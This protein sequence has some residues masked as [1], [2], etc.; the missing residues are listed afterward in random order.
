MT[1]MALNGVDVGRLEDTIDAISANPELAAFEFRS[2]TY[3]KGGSKNETV[4]ADY[5]GA[6]GELGLDERSFVQAADEPEIL[7]GKDSAPN[8]TEHLLAALAGC[9]TTSLV[10]HAAARGLAVE[11]V[12]AELRGALDLRGF[13]GLSTAVRKG[14]SNIDV[15]LRVQSE[16]S[17]EELLACARMSPVYDTVSHGT[18]VA[19]HIEK[20]GPANTARN[21]V[22]ER[23]SAP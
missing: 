22:E 6:G 5:H 10:Y 1:S 20:I 21:E 17:D 7:L 13:L 15:T 19:L 12:R 23:P 14:F 3:W 16:A 8:P 18:D 4:L 9:L 11:D 2:H